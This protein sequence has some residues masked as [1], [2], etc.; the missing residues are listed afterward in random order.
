M[1]A[2]SLNGDGAT[3][4]NQPPLVPQPSCRRIVA[5]FGNFADRL[6]KPAQETLG[7]RI[8]TRACQEE[9]LSRLVR[10]EGRVS[11]GRCRLRSR[12]G[13]RAGP[14]ASR[15]TRPPTVSPSPV[16]SNESRD[17]SRV[18]PFSPKV[19]ARTCSSP[20]PPS[21]SQGRGSRS[22]RRHLPR[23]QCPSSAYP[24]S[25]AATVGVGRHSRTVSVWVSRL[26]LLSGWPGALCS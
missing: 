22:T 21:R 20:P 19:L 1:L 14:V 23:L 13:P 8:S 7:L 25:T 18:G 24:Y 17:E 12:Q 10:A 5:T 4:A 11:R 15:A 6:S 2:R 26:G 16:S 3:R 9:R